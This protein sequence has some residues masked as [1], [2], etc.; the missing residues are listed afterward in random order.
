MNDIPNEILF[1]IIEFTNFKSLKSLT[2]INIQIK[3]CYDHVNLKRLN[4]FFVDVMKKVCHP[5]H[6]VCE[7]P[8]LKKLYNDSL[9]VLSEMKESLENKI[10]LSNEA[11]LMLK[12]RSVVQSTFCFLINWKAKGV[13]LFNKLR[14]C[15]NSL[16]N[17]SSVRNLCDSVN[18]RHYLKRLQDV[19]K[20]RNCFSFRNHD[21]YKTIRITQ[22]INDK[23]TLEDFEK[24]KYLYCGKNCVQHFLSKNFSGSSEL[25]ARIEKTQI[26]YGWYNLINL[27]DTQE[28]LDAIIKIK[29]FQNDDVTPFVESLYPFPHFKN[30]ILPFLPL[31]DSVSSELSLAIKQI[32]VTFS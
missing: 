24:M 11:K 18:K 16:L 19:E 17:S 21:E 14:I 8:L 31:A 4:H 23:T 3:L 1:R 5:E 32:R 30:Q 15:L 22:F 29:K 10:I 13:N 2:L 12:Y 9:I 27:V 7:T 6:P 20:F 28:E 26:Q 25:L